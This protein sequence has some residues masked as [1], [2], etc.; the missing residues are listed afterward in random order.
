MRK[1]MVFAAVVFWA[2]ILVAGSNYQP[3]NVKA[4]LWQVTGETHYSGLP[5]ASGDQ[6]LPINYKTCVTQKDLNTNPWAKGS[7]EKC[8]WKLLNSTAT[9]MEVQGTSCAA[10]RADG[11]QSEVTIKYHAVSP[12][13]VKATAQ[14]TS[15]GNGM[16][17][18]FNSSFNG[19]WVSSSCPADTK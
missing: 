9:D 17:L 11:M 18:K 4:G 10:G 1:L 6:K 16:S 7:D 15:V 13:T 8:N 14:G 2:T 12:E 5:N 3:M 19:R